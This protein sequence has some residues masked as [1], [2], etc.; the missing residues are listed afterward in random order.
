[1]ITL[2]YQLRVRKMTIDQLLMIEAI[3]SEGSYQAAARKLNKSQP[4]LSTG[5][6]KI[7]ELYSITLFSREGYRPVLTEVGK[8]FFEATRTALSSYRQLHKLASEL[9][10]GIEPEIGLSIDPIVFSENIRPLM[11]TLRRPNYR[12]ILKLTSGVLFDNAN[13]VLNEEVDLALGNLP[14]LNDKKIEHVK[15]CAIDLVPVIHKKLIKDKEPDTELLHS[16]PNIVVSTRQVEG[17][18][19]SQPAGLK[20]YV[21]THSRKSDLI[22]MGMGWGRIS[23]RELSKQRDLKLLP[24][25]L[26]GKITIDIH[27][28]RNREKPHGP[29]AQEIWKAM[30]AD[31]QTT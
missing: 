6:K 18:Q 16:I 3:I 29:V 25:E 28:M 4:S 30:L 15:F 31:F 23:Q 9:G 7:E 17:S 19:I 8:R 5:I 24:Q 14:Q 13:K 21:D 2:N 22:I 27:L 26:V 20:W 1:L 12:S 10:A 11:E